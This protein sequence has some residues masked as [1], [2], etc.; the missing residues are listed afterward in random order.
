MFEVDLSLLLYPMSGAGARV[1]GTFKRD[2][3]LHSDMSSDHTALAE[4]AEELFTFPR[5]LVNFKPYLS[6]TRCHLGLRVV[7][8][9]HFGT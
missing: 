1:K 7:A 9:G 8:Q 3:G 4:V 6:L 5:S 2:T